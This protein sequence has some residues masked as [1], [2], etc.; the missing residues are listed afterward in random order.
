MLVSIRLVLVVRWMKIRA[1]FSISLAVICLLC[2]VA[3]ASSDQQGASSCRESLD[4]AATPYKGYIGVSTYRIF[5]KFPPDGL[6]E[7][8]LV[9][10]YGELKSKVG[11]VR[12]SS[13]CFRDQ[14]LASAVWYPQGKEM[15]V[16][17]ND[18]F[19][20][21]VFKRENEYLVVFIY[22]GYINVDGTADEVAAAIAVYDRDGVLLSVI[23]RAASWANNEGTLVLRE[24]CLAGD[25]IS[26]S[27]RWIY[28]D[29]RREDG[30]VV[31]YEPTYELSKE[32]SVLVDGKSASQG[33]YECPSNFYIRVNKK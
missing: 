13:D 2:N 4:A 5:N 23:E 27:D 14:L 7:V 32:T 15:K 33:G 24:A 6:R 12:I 9:E 16:T 21:R 22:S 3:Y 28:P 29:K 31:S 18:I 20:V 8:D 25:M 30:E 10:I 19:P 1:F 26:I 11:V 17:N